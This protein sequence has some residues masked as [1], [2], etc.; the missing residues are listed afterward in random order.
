MNPP[1]I[2]PIKWSHNMRDFVKV[3]LTKD[4]RQ[5]PTVD[6]LLSHPFMS[7][8]DYAKGKDNYLEIL[9]KYLE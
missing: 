7:K 5:R 3:C 6:E 1:E 8:M 9:K 4:P 2:D